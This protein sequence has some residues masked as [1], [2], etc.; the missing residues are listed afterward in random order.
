MGYERLGLE[1]P[2]WNGKY[3]GPKEIEHGLCEYSKYKRMESQILRDQEP[4]F[5][6]RMSRA[7]FDKD[8]AC[9][10]CKGDSETGFLC[11]TC[12]DFYCKACLESSPKKQDAGWICVRCRRFEKELL[13]FERQKE[14]GTIYYV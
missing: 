3:V 9:R 12:L 13:V 1:M 2:S 14:D 11:D 7:H 4:N 10:T 8:R 5:R 6:K